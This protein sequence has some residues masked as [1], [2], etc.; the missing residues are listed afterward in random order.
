MTRRF[1]FTQGIAVVRLRSYP[2]SACEIVITFLSS[3]ALVDYS[4]PILESGD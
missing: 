4:D 3:E 2:Y 1:D